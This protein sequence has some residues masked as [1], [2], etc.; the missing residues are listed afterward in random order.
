ME[1]LRT[2]K[3]MGRRALLAVLLSGALLGMP[4]LLLRSG[5]APAVGAATTPAPSA[6]GLMAPWQ[7]VHFRAV[8]TEKAATTTTAPPTTTTTVPPTTTTTAPPPPTT[9]TA[10]PPPPTTT[11]TA[12]PPPPAPTHSETGIA[13]WYSEAPA[14]TC[15]SPTLTFGTVL[16]VT[17][18]ATGASTSCVV[19]DRE[20]DNPGRVV[21]MS[22]SGFSAIAD[23]SAGVVTVTISW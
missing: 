7:L 22:Y 6:L 1:I 17:N 14:G 13:T 5:S 23:P 10:P 18:V 15:A 3:A 19:A 21:D 11:T 2:E 8:A 9:T 16:E 12:P 4:L 20:A